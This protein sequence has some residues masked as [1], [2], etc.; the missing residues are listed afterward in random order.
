ME[1]CF[2]GSE[3]PQLTA[4]ITALS[5]IVVIINEERKI[6]QKQAKGF[7]EHQDHAIQATGMSSVE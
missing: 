4:R 2:L 5:K 3:R 7:Y 1:K 6:F